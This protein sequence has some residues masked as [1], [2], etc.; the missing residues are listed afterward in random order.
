MIIRWHSS[1]FDND[2]KARLRNVIS[3][4][5]SNTQKTAVPTKVAGNSIE[6]KT[7]STFWNQGRIWGLAY[8]FERKRELEV[9]VVKNARMLMAFI[10]LDRGARVHFIDKWHFTTD[11]IFI[12]YWLKIWNSPRIPQH[13]GCLIVH[14]M[15][16]FKAAAKEVK[17]RF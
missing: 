7:R 3:H 10:F 11:S 13:A 16:A 2:A 1:I 14:R 4:D 9:V 12:T 5:L 15:Y 17:R 8:Y 6:R